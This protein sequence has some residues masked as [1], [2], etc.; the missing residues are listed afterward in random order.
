MKGRQELVRQASRRGTFGEKG[1]KDMKREIY[2]CEAH[3][4]KLHEA[5]YYM[6]AKGYKMS[7]K[8]ES[9]HMGRG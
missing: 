9:G 6:I 1:T 4:E 8:E 2:E 3:F 5:H 7:A